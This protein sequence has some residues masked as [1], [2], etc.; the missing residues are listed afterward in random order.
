MITYVNR[1]CLDGILKA[2]GNQIV[3]EVENL[4]QVFTSTTLFRIKVLLRDYI[5]LYERFLYEEQTY[6]LFV[7]NDLYQPKTLTKMIENT[8][9]LRYSD[10]DLKAIME[11]VILCEVEK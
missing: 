8:L 9:K 6:T 4:K 3:G 7:P 1:L 5:S 11:R 2:L 10:E